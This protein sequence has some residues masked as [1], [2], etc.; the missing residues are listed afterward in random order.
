MVKLWIGCSLSRPASAATALEIDAGAEP[1]PD[2]HVAAHVQSH[3][4]AQ[5]F[6]QAL[7]PVVGAQ[8]LGLFVRSGKA[9][10]PIAVQRL[11]AILVEQIF[12]GQEPPHATAWRLRTEGIAEANQHPVGLRIGREIDAFGESQDRLLLRREIE[13]LRRHRVVQRLDAKAIARQH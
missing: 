7:G 11:P 6:Q 12:P 5:L 3:C 4:F 10:G 1:G 9:R 8:P 2:R 13:S